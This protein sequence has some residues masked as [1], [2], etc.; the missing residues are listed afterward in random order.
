MGSPEEGPNPLRPYYI[1]PS[2]GLPPPS[3]SHAQDAASAS[4]PASAQ[5]RFGNSARDL[6]TE[7]DYS[8][9]LSDSSPSISGS[10]KDLLDRAIWKYANVLMAQP[11]ETAKTIL[12]ANV[13]QGDEQE[14]EI[15]PE[16]RQRRDHRFGGDNYYD[17]VR[18]SGAFIVLLHRN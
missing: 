1:P 14:G 12:Q 7:L 8:D 17:D 6:L 18:S 4:I 13:V 9:Y 2:I 10:T 16:E 3:S 11:F 5:A 15:V